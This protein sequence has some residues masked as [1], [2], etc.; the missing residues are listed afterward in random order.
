VPDAASYH[1]Q[2]SEAPDFG[3]LAMDE[4]NIINT[5][6]T[7]SLESGKTYHWRIAAAN[8]EGEGPY[9]PSWSFSTA[10]TGVE[11]ADKMIPDAFA[12]QPVYPNPFNATVTIT[13]DV[14]ESAP[15]ELV[16]YNT[17]GQAIK[18]LVSGVQPPGSHV[19]QWHG[20]DE[21]GMHVPSGLYICRMKTENHM[22][23]QKMMLLQ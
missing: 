1:A 23:I 9:S 14:P 17:A 10:G 2:V 6:Y 5:R 15:I 7:A 16:V 13:Y 3:S 19:I 21:S 18:T 12:L 22:F 20:I 8:A 4:E 11:R